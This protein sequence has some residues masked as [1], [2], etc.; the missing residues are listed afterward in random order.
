MLKAVF[1]LA[2]ATVLQKTKDNSIVEY[3]EHLIKNK[4]IAEHNARNAVA[5]KIATLAY[6]VLKT[7]TKYEPYRRVV[8]NK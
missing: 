4:N 2:T 8:R 6:G 7:K 1:K 3:Y 5:R